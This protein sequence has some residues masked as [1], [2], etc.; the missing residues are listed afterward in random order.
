[1][2]DAPIT[3]MHRHNCLEIGYC[4]SGAGIFV[5]ED[6]TLPYRAGDVSIISEAEMHQA[7]SIAGMRSEWTFVEVDPLALVPAPTEER[8]LLLATAISSIPSSTPRSSQ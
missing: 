5:V 8:W 4:H 7:W 2:P 6:K 3:F 1:M